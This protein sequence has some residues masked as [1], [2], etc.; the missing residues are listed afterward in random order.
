MRIRRHRLTVLAGLLAV[1]TTSIA[2]GPLP[3]APVA[4]ADDGCVHPT[5]RIP[6]TSW[7][8]Q[9]LR[10]AQVWPVTQGSGQIVAVIDSGVDTGRPHLAAPGAVIAGPDFLGQPGGPSTRDCSGHGTGVAALIAGRPVPGSPFAGV[11]PR[12]TVLSI[13]EFDSG[14]TGTDR[15][16]STAGLARAI[17][18]AVAGHAGV[19]NV[20]AVTSG[21]DPRLRAAVAGALAH[22]V[23]VVAAAGND[24]PGVADPGAD[25]LVYF[26]AAYPGVLAVAASDPQDQPSRVSHAGPY[27]HIA[28][29][30]ED[31][32]TVGANGPAD[33]VRQSG[34]SFAAPFVSG[35]AALVRAYHPQ[36]SAR[37]VVDR[38]IATADV[39]PAGSGTPALGAGIVDPYAAVTAV[40]PAE[41]RPGTVHPSPVAALRPADPPADRHPGRGLA[42]AGAALAGLLALLVLAGA[43][44]LPRG[45]AG[46]WQPG[47]VSPRAGG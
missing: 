2:T 39:P 44:L 29:P 32:V 16:G 26:P 38:L 7:A 9:R 43:A 30:G 36:L 10:L 14:T 24:D 23:V 37:Q 46:R 28:A 18:A 40:I 45:R 47:R 27:V 11:A 42:L 8:Q 1:L 35:A 5:D 20:S 13:R 15:R 41:G 3:A 12:A 19:I 4:A 6:P 25:R 31:V 17:A 21:D 34:T 22:D 33:Y